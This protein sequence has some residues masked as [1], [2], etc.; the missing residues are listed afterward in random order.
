MRP[1][2]KHSALFSILLLAA[3]GCD[4]PSSTSST[5]AGGSTSASSTDAATSTATSGSSTSSGMTPTCEPPE[6]TASPTKN[7]A[8]M[9]ASGTVVDDQDMPVEANLFL[10]LCGKNICLDG[11]TVS[12][13]TYVINAN[14]A[15]MDRPFLKAGD[16]LTFAKIGFPIAA[17]T[18]TVNGITKKLTDSMTELVPG[19]QA[20]AGMVKLVVKEDAVLSFDIT[21]PEDPASRSFRAAVFP[22]QKNESIAKGLDFAQIV[23]LGPNETLLCP[24]AALTVPNDAGLPP[25]A[26]VEF[27]L[28]EL[29]I[30]ESFG[31]YGDW[32]SVA[33]GVVSS[34]GATISTDDKTG[35]AV[36]GVYGIR[37]L[38]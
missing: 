17:P 36:L 16:G 10:Q 12:G 3:A 33:T 14:G 35:I 34:D 8:F 11:K 27:L 7:L 25:N 6:G 38:K 28:Q 22:A 30:F 26:S 37:P 32:T 23:A 5:A 4:D 13:G 20:T 9:S 21:I 15:D 2:L 31:T 19:A 24:A 29:S 1:S 18:S